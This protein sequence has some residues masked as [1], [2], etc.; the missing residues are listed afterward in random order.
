MTT[1][2][3]GLRGPIPDLGFYGQGGIMMR[4]YWSV[5]MAPALVPGPA[6]I[7]KGGAGATV[8]LARDLKPGFVEVVGRN[9]AI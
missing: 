6:T 1:R 7:A 2:V 9:R 8:K 5:V 3:P 4:R